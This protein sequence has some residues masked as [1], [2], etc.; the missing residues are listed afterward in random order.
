MLLFSYHEPSFDIR[1]GIRLDVRKSSWGKQFEPG[2]YEKRC[3]EL[4]ERIG[5]SQFLWCGVEAEHSI[6]VDRTEW[7]FDIPDSLVLKVLNSYVWCRLIKDYTFP[8]R[9]WKKAARKLYP[10]DIINQDKYYETLEKEWVKEKSDGELWD[11]LFKDKAEDEDDSL[12][13]PYPVLDSHIVNV[14]P[15]PYRKNGPELIGPSL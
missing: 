3:G 11:M 7:T 2:L 6:W 10:N 8:H 12:L 9:R 13:I 14:K 5:T 1:A 4:A 15:C